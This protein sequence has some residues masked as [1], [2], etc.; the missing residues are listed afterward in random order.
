VEIPLLVS[1]LKR[2][3]GRVDVISVSHIRADKQG[4]ASHREVTRKYIKD[5][6]IPWPVYEDPDDAIAELYR[7]ISTPTTYF[8]SPQGTV[9]DA[10]F[11]PHPTNFDA[12]MARA[13][14]QTASPVFAT[15]TCSPAAATPGPTLALDVLAPE[16]RKV[17]LATLLDKPAVVHLWA[18]WC[19]PCMEELPPLLKFGQSIEKAGTGR[20]VLLSVE[21]A[22]SGDKIAGFAKKYNLP[23]RSNRAPT[24]PLADAVDLSY[25][26]PRTFIV[27]PG[28]ALVASRQGSQKWDD[29]QFDEKI[30]SRLRNAAALAR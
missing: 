18:T 23:L 26:L 22:A 15:S 2:N 14:A 9:A 20:L 10:W 21:D 19:A 28:G 7:S 6:Q 1:W 16:G 27:A 30:L 8:V 12:E 29:P 13:L 24:G 4:F 5:Q 17:P 11:Y 3:P 25:R